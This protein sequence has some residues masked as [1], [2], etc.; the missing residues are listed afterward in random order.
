[1]TDGGAELEAGYLTTAELAGRANFS[2]GEAT[3]SPSRRIVSGP[4]GNSEVEPRVMQVLVVLADSANS[5]VTRHTLFH[6]CWGNSEVG[7]DSLNRTIA[8][9]RKLGSDIGGGSFAVETIPRTGYRL[10]CDA[11]EESVDAQPGRTVPVARP[12][13][14]RRGA[15]GVGAGVIMAGTA[16]TILWSARQEERKVQALIREA[17]ATLD[18]GDNT[19]DPSKYLLEAVALDPR[20]ATAQG[21]LAF[22]LALNSDFLG[23]GQTDAIVNDA[24]RAA[25]ASLAIDPKDPNAKLAMILLRRASL[26]L[27]ATEDQLRQLLASAPTNNLV[28]RQLWNL[29]Q[30]AGRSRDAL[31]LVEQAISIK[32]L[33][34]A[35]NFPLGQLLW[36]VGR[37]PEADRVLERAISYWPDHRFV[38]FARFNLLA[39]TGRA[40]AALAMLESKETAPQVFSPKAVALLRQLLAALID[41]TGPNRAIARNATGDAVARDPGLARVAVLPLAALGEIDAA[42]EIANQLLVFYLPAPASPNRGQSSSLAWRFA[43][44]LFTPPAAAMRADPRFA[45]LCEGTGLTAYWRKRGIEPDYV[46]FPG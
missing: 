33:A 39:Y 41:P 32:P 2:L 43:P 45:R 3:V 23:D 34:A 42:F 22:T 27:A 16:G 9:V 29:L 19:L 14:S 35:N 13:L 36:I 8:A 31:A 11:R 18:Y 37:A 24:E 7:D 17:A 10:T 1:L 40:R 46:R 30:S 12:V 6:R 21:M 26:D 25:K 15:I 20:N 44:W 38:R 4:G 5:V 28:M